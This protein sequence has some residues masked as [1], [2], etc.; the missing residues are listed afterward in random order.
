VKLSKHILDFHLSLPQH[1]NIPNDVELIYPFK[2]KETQRVMGLFFEKYYHDNHPRAYI[3]G[4]NPGRFGSGITGIGFC[5]AYNLESVCDISNSFDKRRETSADFIYEVIEAYGGAQKFYQDFYITSTLPMGLLK[6]SKN[7]N[8]YDD[9]TTQNHL[10]SFI[11]ES[12]QT[13]MEWTSNKKIV[14]I[15]QGKNLA[16]LQAFNDKHGLFESIHTVPHPRWVM[17]YKRKDKA[18]HIDAY[19]E[20][21]SDV[22]S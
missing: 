5:D 4:I 12:I 11:Q 10:E 14:C 2:G 22:K 8:Y 16:Y 13:Q 21:L 18:K 9:K 20:V 15:G 1:L 6:N 19:L 7:Y 3:F 17:Q